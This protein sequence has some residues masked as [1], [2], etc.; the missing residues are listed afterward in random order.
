VAALIEDDDLPK[1]RKPKPLAL[2]EAELRK[3]LNEA[4][5]PSSRSKKRGNLSSQT[6]FYPAVAFAAYTGARR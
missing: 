4:K 2:T 3:L 6:W 5:T 1:A